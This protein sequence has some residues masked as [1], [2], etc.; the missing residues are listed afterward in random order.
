MRHIPAAHSLMTTSP[1][2]IMKKLTVKMSVEVPRVPG[3]LR[4]EDGQMVP[5]YAIT[6]GGLRKL[7]KEWIENL[8][9]RSREMKLADEVKSL[10]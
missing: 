7:G 3:F 2:R 8:V 4:T 6:E 9:A 5:L 1:S 10:E